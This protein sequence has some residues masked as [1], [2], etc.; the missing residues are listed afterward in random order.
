MKRTFKGQQVQRLCNEQGYLQLH[1][2]AQILV[3][4]YLWIF[5]EWGIYHLSDQP[6][7]CCTTLII[8]KFFLLSILIWFRIICL[9]ATLPDKTCLQWALQHLWRSCNHGISW[10]GRN[11]PVQLLTAQDSTKNHTMWLSIV[12]M[13]LELR[14]IWCHGCFL[15]NLF[16]CSTSECRIFSWHLT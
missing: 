15:G 3:Q 5:W 10:V 11:H 9:I 13:L 12:Q 16:Q 14:Q 2:V 1:Q 8:R 6:V 7:K 4:T